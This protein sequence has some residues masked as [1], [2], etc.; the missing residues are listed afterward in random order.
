MSLTHHTKKGVRRKINSNVPY[1]ETEPRRE[2]DLEANCDENNSNLREFSHF[3]CYALIYR[4]G[5]PFYKPCSSLPGP[6]ITD[7]FTLLIRLSLASRD[8]ASSLFMLLLHL[9][10]SCVQQQC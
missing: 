1:R 10:V 2:V 4:K 8:Q 9:V 5:K 6:L 3:Q 7:Y